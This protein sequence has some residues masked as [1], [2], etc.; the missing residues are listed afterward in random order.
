[1][2]F[3]FKN[4]IAW[5]SHLINCRGESSPLSNYRWARTSYQLLLHTLRCGND[6]A[7]AAGS[8]PHGAKEACCLALEGGGRR[9]SNDLKGDHVVA[10][11]VIHKPRAFGS[12]RGQITPQRSSWERPNITMTIPNDETPLEVQGIFFER[13]KTGLQMT[14]SPDQKTPYH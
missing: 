13:S 5:N 9:L 8:K 11:E 10:H 3:I 1:M 7:G 4:P 2:G 14:S 12:R 6:G